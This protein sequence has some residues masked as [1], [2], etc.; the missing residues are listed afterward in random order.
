M[1]SNIERTASGARVTGTLRGQPTCSG[2]LL[3]ALRRL[4]EGGQGSEVLRPLTGKRRHRAARI[5][6]R[7]ALQVLDLEGDPLVLRALCTEVGRT[8]VVTAHAEVG[9]TV[10]TTDDRKELR[11]LDGHRVVRET[12]LLRP[13]RHVRQVLHSERLF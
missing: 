5:H 8:E 12:L 7:G 11:A 3:A 1:R 4:Q 2:V 6:A 13:R 10:E 9:V